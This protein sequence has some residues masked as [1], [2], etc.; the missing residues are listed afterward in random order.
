MWPVWFRLLN[1][2]SLVV[3]CLKSAIEIPII[4]TG[5]N[6]GVDEILVLGSYPCADA[7]NNPIHGYRITNPYLD[8]SASVTIPWNETD[9]R[10]VSAYSD[11]CLYIP[12]IGTIALPASELHINDTSLTVH[13]VVNITSGDIAVEVKGGTSH[14]IYCTAS[15]NCA[16][17][18][19]YGSTGIDTNR[20]TAA[21]TSGIGTVIGAGVAIASG[22]IGALAAAGIGGGLASVASNT[23]AALG[24]NASGSGGLGGGAIS[25]LDP[26]IKCW[27]I[28][29]QLSDT[30]ANLD[31]IIGKPY[32]KKSTPGSFSGYV[33][34]DGFQ[35]E[36]TAAFSHEKDMI[37]SL[38]D[39]GIYYE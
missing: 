3:Q 37:N 19:A 29:K 35:F 32:S 9:W 17:P 8:G 24:G 2:Y 18:T 20:M 30:Q 16:M 5:S 6:H 26:S 33:Q 23:I 11:V 34:T 22:G 27:V 25:Q 21:I 38:M 4:F 12:F 36:S 10:C 39:S 13:I 1:S 31:S 15:G 14:R 28:T 7:L